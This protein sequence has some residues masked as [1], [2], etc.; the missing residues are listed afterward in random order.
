[1]AGAGHRLGK[2]RSNPLDAIAPTCRPLIVLRILSDD[3]ATN[4]RRHEGGEL[5]NDGYRPQPYGP[6]LGGTP[7]ATASGE[8]H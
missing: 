1:M 6:I 7:V 4:R 8:R 3:S 2:W 5:T